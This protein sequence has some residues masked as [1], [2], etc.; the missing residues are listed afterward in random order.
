MFALL[1]HAL[2]AGNFWLAFVNF[3]RNKVR[4]IFALL[5]GVLSLQGNINMDTGFA[6][7]FRMGGNVPLRAYL[8]YSASDLD[9]LFKANPLG[10]EVDNNPIRLFQV[11]NT[12]IPGVNLDAEIGR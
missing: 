1:R 8:V 7:R 5:V 11:S 12:R 4:D 3:Q 2:H 9:Y 6:G 10:V